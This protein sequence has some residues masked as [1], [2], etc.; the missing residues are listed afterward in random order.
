MTQAGNGRSKHVAL[1]T[2]AA[3]GLGASFA[4][5]LARDGFD[6]VLVDRQ[7]DKLQTLA[8]GLAR[9]HGIKAH[10][11]VQD[12]TQLDAVEKIHARCQALGVRIDTLSCR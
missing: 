10:V 1:I 2:G 4:E 12:L 6:L 3:A 8:D 9:R 7:A 11:V 5:R